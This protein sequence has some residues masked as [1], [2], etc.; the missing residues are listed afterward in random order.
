MRKGKHTFSTLQDYKADTAWLVRVLFQFVFYLTNE[1][2]VKHRLRPHGWARKASASSPC[3]V[4]YAY[5]AVEQV[6]VLG[7]PTQHPRR[8]NIL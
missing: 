8:E 2:K 3:H 4:T 1:V 7:Y 6:G 5:Y